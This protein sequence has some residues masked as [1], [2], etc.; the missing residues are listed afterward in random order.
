[1][2]IRPNTVILF[3]KYN[4]VQFSVQAFK[5]LTFTCDGQSVTEF[6]FKYDQKKYHN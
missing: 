3:L 2:Q 6:K 4:T 1:V 5:K